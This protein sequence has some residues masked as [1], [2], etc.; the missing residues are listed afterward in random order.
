MNESYAVMLNEQHVGSL[1]RDAGDGAEFRLSEPYKRASPRPVLGQ[2]FLDDP[3]HVH[4]TRIG[5]PP[6][7][8]NLLPE[9]RLRELIAERAGVHSSRELRLLALLGDDLPGAVRVVAEDM[10]DN[11]RAADD[12]ADYP[13]PDEPADGWK[14]SLAGVQLKFSARHNERGLTIPVSGVGGDW[15]VKLPDLRYPEAPRNEY[16][17]MLWAQA[18]GI[19]V[20]R[21]ELISIGE[22][23]GL[24]ALRL[25][26]SESGV[27]A[28]KRF[29][30]TDDGGRVH[31][32][33]FAQVLGVYP[34]DKYRQC[35]YETLANLIF[36]LTGKDGLTQF[37]RRLIFVVASGNGDAHLKNWSLRYPDGVSA[38]LAP[39]YDLVSTVVYDSDDGLALNLAK[40]KDWRQLDMSA[41]IRL[42]GKIGFPEAAMRD[43]V[44]EALD[45]VLAA[46]DG[47]ARSGLYPTEMRNAL[48]KHLRRVPLL[49]G[50]P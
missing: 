20:P 27:Y 38:C 44:Q 48:A 5:V 36:A 4:H 12:Q 31:M 26:E 41:F 33:D 35:N 8:S 45:V 15:I 40:T 6:W 29:D 39:A 2:M 28:V 11:V 25:P 17:T 9:G 3:D 22:I 21:A 30:R 19:E 32:E 43:I 18:S 23:H 46:W 13:H 14:F 24:P 37:I 7:F 49:R 50:S 42:A 34:R 47:I 10:P 16:A 1:T